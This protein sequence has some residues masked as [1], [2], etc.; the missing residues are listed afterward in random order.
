MWV[1]SLER[2]VPCKAMLLGWCAI[3]VFEW[4]SCVCLSPLIAFSVSK[5]ISLVYLVHSMRCSDSS[6]ANNK[7]S[8]LNHLCWFV[9]GR[10]R[11]RQR[12]QGMWEWHTTM[13]WTWTNTIEIPRQYTH[14]IMKRR[15][16]NKPS[17][18]NKRA[19]WQLV[20]T[21]CHCKLKLEAEP[22]NGSRSSSLCS[23]TCT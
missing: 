19:N 9:R 22:F 18:L 2:I 11:H 10:E 23:E 13:N 17:L 6:Y 7:A 3:G 12:T 8:S 5:E 14:I 1:Q 16:C 15:Q 4:S 20:K 21:L